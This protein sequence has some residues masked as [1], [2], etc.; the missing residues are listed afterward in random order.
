MEASEGSMTG[1]LIQSLSGMVV[2]SQPLQGRTS[3]V[4]TQGKVP[5]PFADA[6]RCVG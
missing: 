2:G 5:M 3:A 1:A 6:I 4:L